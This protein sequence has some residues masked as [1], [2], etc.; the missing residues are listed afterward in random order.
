LQTSYKVLL[1]ALFV[2]ALPFA[3]LIV[4]AP[5]SSAQG[6]WTPNPTITSVT[7]SGTQAVVQYTIPSGEGYNW[8]GVAHDSTLVE[9][10]GTLADDYAECLTFGATSCTVPGIQPGANYFLLQTQITTAS[11][12][13]APP[14][15]QESSYPNGTGY[16]DSNIFE[17]SVGS[18]A[19]TT[20]TT[21]APSAPLPGESTIAGISGTVEVR[22][23]DGSWV[24]VANGAALHLGQEMRTVTDSKCTLTFADGTQIQ[25]GYNSSFTPIQNTSAVKSSGSIVVDFTR[26]ILRWTDPGYL[27]GYFGKLK[28]RSNGAVLGVRGT[29][30]VISRSVGT[31]VEASIAVHQGR[32]TYT[33]KSGKALTLS[34]GTLVLLYGNS[35]ARRFKLTNS[36][37]HS[38]VSGA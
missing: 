19:T 11:T 36:D 21:V 37:W 15:G 38:Y 35:T 4:I 12:G 23:A 27:R 31:Q 29:D 18:S 22:Q 30:F 28:V 26:G 5:P 33:P 13:C 14:A 7:I 9:I 32:L 20:T 2:V 24:Q 10:D 8:A 17:V 6:P 16:C 1:G 34:A 25:L 3:F